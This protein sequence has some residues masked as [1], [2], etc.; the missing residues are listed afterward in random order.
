MFYIV[1]DLEFN[2]KDKHYTSNEYNNKTNLP[3]EIIQIGA[4]KLNEDFEI[5]SAFNSLI[6]PTVYT[7]IHPYIEELTKIKNTDVQ[8][9]PNFN[10]VIN[11][12]IDFIGNEPS[13]LCVWGQADISVLLQNLEF[14]NL[15]PLLLPKNYI[16]IQLHASKFFNA[17]SGSR[18]GLRN[19][20]ELLNIPINSNF[21]NAF[22]DAFYTS[23]VFKE[24]YSEKVK[25]QPIS[26]VRNN[27]K[28]RKKS[29][30][31]IDFY[32]L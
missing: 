26:Y 25:I 8:D 12:F 28:L 21:H 9:A 22:N 15:S 30:E 3:F 24:I 11:K 17:P 20:I 32:N 29:K 13:T 27:N 4:V 2:Q 7:T 10:V 16:D 14:H 23:K 18:I 5:V 6:K 19:S 1:Y 31:K